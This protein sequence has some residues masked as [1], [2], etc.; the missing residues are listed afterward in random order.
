MLRRV[1]SLSSKALNVTSTRLSSSQIQS[2][3]EKLENNPYFVKYKDRISAMKES[4]PETYIKR[5]ELMLSQHG[6]QEKKEAGENS[7]ES[8][9]QDIF[10]IFRENKKYMK[11]LIFLN[12][13]N[14]F[15]LYFFN[16]R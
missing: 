14:Y 15:L 10:N 2:L 1:M 3:E 5:L 12:Q 6:K 9:Q 11:V 7:R 16:Q 8:T 13:R 4:D